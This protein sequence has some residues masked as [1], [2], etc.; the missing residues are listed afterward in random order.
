MMFMVWATRGA[1]HAAVV[2]GAAALIASAN[3]QPSASTGAIRFFGTGPGSV[4]QQDR[5]RIPIDDNIADAP[6]ASQPCDVGAGSFTIDFWIRGEL[7][8]NTSIAPGS[9]DIEFF[10]NRWIEGN[11]IVDR[12]IW[13]GSSRDWGISIAG[14]RIRFGTGRGVDTSPDSEHTIEGS[15]NVLTGEW[16][17]IAV[18]RNAAVGSKAI[19]VDGVL[20]FQC[21]GGRSQDDISYPNLGDPTPVTEWGPYIVL[22]AE[23]H[24]AGAEF[25]S[26]SGYLDEFRVWSL[27]LSAA[28]IE[29][30]RSRIV[31]A[32]SAR[33]EGLVGS[34][35]FEESTGTA[36]LDSSGS[37]QAAGLLI[38]NQPGNGQRVF[39]STDPRNTAPIQSWCAADFNTDAQLGV[40]DIF[41]YLAAYFSSLPRADFNLSGAVTVQDMFDFL[42]S[43]FAGC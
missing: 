19:Y 22:G 21:P 3:G 42:T 31:P 9:G 16:R 20:D 35:R 23:K 18:V 40:Q 17:H 11:I 14:G 38:A 26:Y 7:A 4:G 8:D 10:D 2:A 30:A 12:D 27:A 28:D 25:P 29:A 36:V 41:D 15:T 39:A 13:G 32:G 5:V 6:D 1:K 33:A 34:F 24:D 37:G 43:Y